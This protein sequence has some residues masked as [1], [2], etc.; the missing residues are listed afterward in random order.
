M[1]TR[2]YFYSVKVAH[3]NDTG[4]YSWH[5]SIATT[6]GLT[7][8]FDVLMIDIRRQGALLMQSRIER[9]IEEKDIEIVSLNRV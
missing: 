5:H 3:N 8:D 7:V 6:T 2:K 4:D 9:P 1:I